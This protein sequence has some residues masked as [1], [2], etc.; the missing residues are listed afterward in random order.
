[1]IF[2]CQFLS[3]HAQ[4]CILMVNST[5]NCLVNLDDADEKI[6]KKEEYEGDN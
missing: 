6:R 5:L 2:G 4:I 3:Y 1:M